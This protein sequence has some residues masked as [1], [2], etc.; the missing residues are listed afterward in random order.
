MRFQRRHGLTVDGI[1]GPAD[2]RGARPA[3]APAAR[4][5]GDAQRRVAAGTWRRLQYLLARRGYP[6]GAIDG[7][8]GAGHG[9][10]GQQLPARRSGSGSTASPGPATVS[11][12]LRGQLGGA[13]QDRP[14]PVRFFRPVPAPIGDGFGAPRDG[15]SRRHAGSTSRRGVRHARRVR[16]GVGVTEFVGSEPGRLRQPRRGPPSARLTTWYAHLVSITTWVGERVNGGTRLGY[17]GAT[18]NSTGPHLHFE[19][20]ALRQRRSTRLPYLLATIAARHVPAPAP[21]RGAAP[22]GSCS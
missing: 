7:V 4:A 18:G 20:A 1:A 12:P 15:G 19:V 14:G 22:S 2:P 10:G 8:F 13:S 9:G 21:R 5:A 3:R 11:A 6:P 17:V 16:A